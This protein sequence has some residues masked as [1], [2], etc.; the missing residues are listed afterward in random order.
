M[1]QKKRLLVVLIPGSL[2]FV[3][4]VFAI[5]SVHRFN[6][7]LESS[8][9][10]D[11]RHRHICGLK[12]F[13]QIVGDAT[14]RLCRDFVLYYYLLISYICVLFLVIISLFGLV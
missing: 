6:A 1:A 13:T 3:D 11:L 12:Q 4:D 5:Q 9:T 8:M 14:P 2:D 7:N 10:H